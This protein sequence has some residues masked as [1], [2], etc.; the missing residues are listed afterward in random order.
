[1]PRRTARVDDTL[2]AWRRAGL[3]DRPRSRMRTGRH[4]VLV[5]LLI[6]ETAMASL[7]GNLFAGTTPTN[8]GARDGR[9]ARCPDTAN[10]VC[11]QANDDA[12]RIAPLTYTGD[13]ANA[14][15][16][17]ARVVAAQPGAAIVA[18]RPDYL[19]AT[20]ATPLMGFVDDVE[21]LESAGGSTIEVRSASRLGHSDFGVNRKRI[22]TLRV[23]FA[24][25]R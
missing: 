25:A 2:A 6:S 24:E 20:F 13:A 7:F 4:A 15:T 22:E 1:M 10:C 8:L 23:A 19:Y 21:F 14:M 12:H 5:A 17:L 16:R 18:Q 11:S 3:A 9:L